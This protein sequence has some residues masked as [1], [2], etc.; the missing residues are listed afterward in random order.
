MRSGGPALTLASHGPRRVPTDDD[1]TLALGLVLGLSRAE[2]QL[3]ASPS[4]EHLGAQG[5]ADGVSR[6]LGRERAGDVAT[7]FP[8]RHLPLLALVL[9]LGGLLGHRAQTPQELGELLEATVAPHALQQPQGPRCGH[10]FERAWLQ[11]PSTD[12]VGD[13]ANLFLRLEHRS[14]AEPSKLGELGLGLRASGLSHQ[15]VGLGVGFGLGK[16]SKFPRLSHRDLLLGKLVRQTLSLIGRER[17]TTGTGRSRRGAGA[18]LWQSRALTLA[19]L[20]LTLAWLALTLAGVR[21][22][23][24]RTPAGLRPRRFGRGGLL[25]HLGEHGLEGLGLRLSLLG[26]LL[27]LI[28]LGLRPGA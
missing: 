12:R 18:G 8:T 4:L 25:S 9:A 26:R 10:P 27:E 20:A 17:H 1:R 23:A 13:I 5:A 19:W 11:A 24:S 14:H 6:E 3:P 21:L 7:G 15:R 2:F 28:S 22:S 16:I